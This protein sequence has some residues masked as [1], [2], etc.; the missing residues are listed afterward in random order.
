MRPKQTLR[1]VCPTFL[2]C[3][4][5]LVVC[6]CGNGGTPVVTSA[7]TGTVTGYVYVPMG[8]ARVA[9]FRTA[10]AAP[11]G[12]KPLSN[13]TVTVAGTTLQDTTDPTGKYEIP[14]VPA[15]AQQLTITATGYASTTID[16]TITAG[17]T[18]TVGGDSGSQIY[19]SQKGNIRITWTPSAIA[20]DSVK[21]DGDTTG[22]STSP[23]L[24]ENVSAATHTIVI[25][26]SGYTVTPSS[27][28]AVV[29]DGGTTEVSFTLTSNAP[30]ITN[31]TPASGAV[32][33]SV[34]ITGT[35]FGSSQGTSI[36]KFNNVAAT[37]GSWSATSLTCAVPAGA[38]TGTI[39]VTTSEGAVTSSSNFTV[40]TEIVFN[41]QPSTGNRRIVTIKSDGTGRADLTDGTYDDYA[42]AWSPDGTKIAF[43]SKRSGDTKYS[44]YK[45]NYDG[46]GV[47]KL[48]EVSGEDCDVVDWSPDGLNLVLTT[49]ISSPANYKVYKI[50]ADGSG[51]VALASGMD[52]IWNSDGGKILYS[53]MD[54]PVV[55]NRYKMK[56]I[57]ADG[58]GSAI[59]MDFND[60]FPEELSPDG[61]KMLVVGYSIAADMISNAT[62]SKDGLFYTSSGGTGL[63]TLLFES[64]TMMA[65]PYNFMYYCDMG[66]SWSPDGTK[67]VYH[68]N[69][70]STA[71][72]IYIA[73]SDGSGATLLSSE[74][75]FPDWK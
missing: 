37:C 32:G 19:T 17:T 71:H 43:C 46:T 7:T 70:T 54:D 63:L 27:Q 49:R 60:L 28:E 1:V 9:A 56:S 59:F 21:I 3:I 38:T 5:M 48:K 13:A 8:S 65:D 34:A 20:V 68:K 53:D 24:L 18:T 57:N 31:F 25:A 30:T 26:K 23:V 55:S 36:V 45:M 50:G 14:N 29:T 52:G 73:N 62:T 64:T 4:I 40:N 66:C 39:T 2:V 22:F 33:E 41:T 69:G 61:T 47:T 42:P 6:G 74:A 44:L 58:T 12:Y 72:S 51:V 75:A 15:G 67:I 16:V 10:A 35:N 11:A